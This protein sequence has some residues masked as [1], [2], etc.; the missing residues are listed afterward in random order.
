MAYAACAE[1]TGMLPRHSERL[2]L[3][4]LAPILVER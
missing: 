2:F 1:M 4:R 3:E